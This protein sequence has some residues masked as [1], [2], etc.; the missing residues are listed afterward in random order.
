MTLKQA[1]QAVIADF[2]D[3]GHD[4][5]YLTETF[6]ANRTVK[7]RLGP[8]QTLYAFLNAE[9]EP[10][11]GSRV[12]VSQERLTRALVST[13]PP[14]KH[15]QLCPVW[16]RRMNSAKFKAQSPIL[17]DCFVSKNAPLEAQSLMDAIT[18]EERD[19]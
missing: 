17:C 10:L 1:A 15:G 5:A 11:P 6:R 12:E 8:I 2:L 4:P 7:I 13:T 14:N 16:T 3:E 19:G 18:K 9:S